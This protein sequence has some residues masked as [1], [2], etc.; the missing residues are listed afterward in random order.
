MVAKLKNDLLAEE[1]VKLMEHMGATFVDVT[2]KRR[3]RKVIRQENY[4]QPAKSKL[5]KNIL[6]TANMP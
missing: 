1:F 3:D 5:S 6:I 2:P 4:K